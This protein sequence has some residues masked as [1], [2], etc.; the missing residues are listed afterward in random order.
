MSKVISTK[1]T[2]QTTSSV[3]ELDMPE[4]LDR[5][6]RDEIKSEVADF[7]VDQ[8][9]QSVGELKS[10][11]KGGNYKTSLSKEYREFKTGE[12]LQGVADLE[13]TGNMLDS[14]RARPL[15]GN[16]IE[17]GVFG[18]PAKR[19]DG[20]NN[21]SGK[22]TLPPREFLPKQDGSFKRDI[23]AEIKR[24]IFDTASK[25]VEIPNTRLASVRTKTELLDVLAGFLVSVPRQRIPEVVSRSPN[26]LDQLSRLQLLD[27]LF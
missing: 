9:L 26:L 14:L 10:P 20:H 19:A 8:I 16:K 4:G 17:V 5:A 15:S 23:E 21:L 22:S 6:T 13:L 2:N 27:L 18:E 3:Y 24:I 25:K 7:L 1:A 12:G 11:V